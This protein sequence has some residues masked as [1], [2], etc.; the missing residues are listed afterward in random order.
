MARKIFFHTQ[1]HGD[2]CEP[3]SI[4]PS[5]A[6]GGSL[7]DRSPG[8]EANYIESATA[9]SDYGQVGVCYFCDVS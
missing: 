4:K 3:P 8:A 7:L 5:Y 1:A 2:F 6:T 9:L